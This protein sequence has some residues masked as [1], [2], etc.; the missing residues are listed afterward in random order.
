MSSLTHAEAIERARLLS[1]DSYDVELDLT[2][3]PDD[4]GSV[5]RV[6]FGCAEPG[7]STVIQVRGTVSAATLNGTPLPTD[8]ADG[9]LPVPGLAADNELVVEA[10]LAYSH[11]GEGLH[12]AVDPADDE[13]YVYAQCEMDTAPDVF[14]CF[15]QPDLKARITLK[16]SAPEAWTVLGNGTAQ[17]VSPGRWEFEAVGP[18]STYLFTVCGGPY[19]SLY[20]EHAGI[21]LGWHSRRSMAKHLAAEADELFEVTSQSLDWFQ[22][23]F[24]LAY[25]FGT[26]YDQV[27]VPEFLQGAMENIGCVTVRDEWLY[28]SAVTEAQR[29]W[30]AVVIAHEM[31][32]MWFGDLVTLQWWDDLW[33]NE[34]FA[35]YMGW[36]AVAESTRFRDAWTGFLASRKFAGYMA[37]QRP[38]THPVAPD[39]VSDVANAIGNV[40]AITYPKGASALRQLAALLGDDAFFT[41]LRGYFNRHAY[42]NATLADLIREMSAASGLDL[43]DW[44][45]RWLRVPQVSTLTPEL[46]IEDGRLT[47]VAVR[48]TAPAQYPTLRPHRIR[49]GCYRTDSAGALVRDEVVDVVCDP[50][51]DNGRTQVP[52]LVGVP[53]PDL[54]LLNDEDL[55]FARI[56]LS[57][58]DLHRL[59]ELQSKLS[60]PL[61]RTLLWGASWEAVR[62]GQ[63]SPQSFVDTL[64]AGLPVEAMVSVLE[65]MQRCG[66]VVA[67]RYLSDE[68][69]GAALARLTDTY[70]GILDTVPDDAGRRLAA[71]RGVAGS[72]VT[73]EQVALLGDWLSGNRVPEGVAMDAELRWTVL[74]RLVTVGAAGAAEIDAEYER[75]RTATGGVHA[76]HCRAAL[77]DPDAKAAAFA[78]LVADR[79]ASNRYLEAAG[80][81]LW[82]AEHTALTEQYVPRY[83]AELP[84]TAAWR[85]PGMLMISTVYCYPH[86]AVSPETVA[87]AEAVLA[88][89]DLHPVLRRGI[90]DSTHDL[91]IALAVRQ[92]G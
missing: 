25:P 50:T 15:D 58:D 30:R 6:R 26:K 54:L 53:V 31:A 45:E 33:L 83:F 92:T 37:D 23:K 46:S 7:A 3:G 16:V 65:Q 70:L 12:R 90:V 62:S 85:S 79:E 72:A 78:V 5:S 14:A 27:F 68:E 73:D 82:Q 63:L 44:T 59:P 1:I 91:R 87:A 64:V 40:D 19:H 80:T 76:A 22:E 74:H 81:G 86:T 77:P 57:G 38:S 4:F 43:T 24:G 61:A 20:R 18:M 84:D 47:S 49:I 88:R 13:A 17:Q 11:S 89:D 71:A 67:G 51:R 56:E 36:R 34:S 10:R 66:A 39:E 60:D 42:G 9:R 48:Q 32:H 55:T 21:T 29:E 75:D 69:R 41:G 52:E 8:V 35:E 28:T 2:G